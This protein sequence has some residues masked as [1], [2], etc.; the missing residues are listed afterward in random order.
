MEEQLD[1]IDIQADAGRDVVVHPVPQHDLRSVKQD[2]PA[3]QQC[4]EGRVD[5]GRPVPEDHVEQA[6]ANHHHKAHHQKAPHER[7]ILLRHVDVRAECCKNAEG[8]AASPDHNVGH[9]HVGVHCAHGPNGHRLA[10]GEEK[11]EDG[12]DGVGILEP[13]AAEGHQD[14]DRAQHG[15]PHEAPQVCQKQGLRGL[16]P[17]THTSD[18][19]GQG[20]LEKKDGVDLPQE[21]IPQVGMVGVLGLVLLPIPGLDVII[22]WLRRGMLPLVLLRILP[23]ELLYILPLIWLSIL[24]PIWLRILRSGI[25]PARARRLRVACALSIGTWACTLAIRTGAM[26]AGIER[27]LL[28]LIVC[29]V[30]WGDK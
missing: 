4:P 30:S 6:P 14:G 3:E 26:I 13:S 1:D 15:S 18:A 29:H 9:A 17:R 10:Q 7:E 22:V 11:E 27:L 5:E 12:I 21:G 23:L 24:L 2:E 19:D 16:V 25:A 8:D 20:Q 28:M